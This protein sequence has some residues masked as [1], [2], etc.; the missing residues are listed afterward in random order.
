MSFPNIK[1]CL[2]QGNIVV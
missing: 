2:F 1:D